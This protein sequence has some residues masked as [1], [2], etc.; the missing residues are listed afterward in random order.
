MRKSMSVESNGRHRIGVQQAAEPHDVSPLLQG[1]G[2]NT[3][4][5]LL[6]FWSPPVFRCPSLPPMTAGGGHCHACFCQIC[7]RPLARSNRYPLSERG[8]L[9]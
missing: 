8:R 2:G 7:V 4:T 3:G 6:G 1:R 5:G 9:R